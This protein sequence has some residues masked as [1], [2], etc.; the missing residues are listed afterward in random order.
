MVLNAVGGIVAGIWLAINGEWTLIGIGIV[1]LFTAHYILAILLMPSLALATLAIKIGD[2]SKLISVVVGFLSQLYTNILLAGSCFV[3]FSICSSFFYGETRLQFLPYALWSWGMAL[4]PWQYMA[5]Q[6]TEESSSGI[7]LFSASILFLFY[8]ISVF[9]SP[10]MVWI[11][12]FSI[13]VMQ[14][15][16][17]PVLNTF[18]AYKIGQ[19]EKLYD[20]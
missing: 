3:A 2:R 19:Y 9:I 16:I 6:E 14:L 4:G 12:F 1:F 18:M 15:I 8:I 7:T 20:A 11:A 17:I 10:T 13:V 5:S